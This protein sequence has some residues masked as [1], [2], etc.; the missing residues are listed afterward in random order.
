VARYG[1]VY[2]FHGPRER[3]M[4]GWNPAA[5]PWLEPVFQQGEVTIYRVKR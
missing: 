2:V 4:G 1:I 3:E 5:E